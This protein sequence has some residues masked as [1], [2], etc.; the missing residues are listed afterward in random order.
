MQE[1]RAEVMQRLLEC[2]GRHRDR[3]LVRVLGTRVDPE[4][5]ASLFAEVRRC[6]L[7]GP[8]GVSFC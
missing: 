1:A 3:R 7:L 8:G 5:L 6:V 4:L 2:Y